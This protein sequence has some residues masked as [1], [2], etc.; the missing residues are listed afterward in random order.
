MLSLLTFFF[1]TCEVCTCA[2]RQ[3]ITLGRMLAFQCS[4]IIMEVPVKN[5]TFVFTFLPEEHDFHSFSPAELGPLETY[6]YY[7]PKCCTLLSANIGLVVCKIIFF[8]VFSCF[9][10]ST[11]NNP[12]SKNCLLVYMN[13]F[14]SN[15]HL[16]R[17]HSFVVPKRGRLNIV[18]PQS[19]T[20][21]SGHLYYF[22]RTSE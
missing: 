3:Q 8:S 1:L 18:I 14:Q 15:C 5:V 17:W 7:S 12:F 21:Y 19:M 10:M 9:L 4:L 6:V 13:W 20:S 2:W 16:N 22:S 11:A